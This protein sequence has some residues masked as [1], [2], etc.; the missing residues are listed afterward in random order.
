VSH[1]KSADR[2]SRFYQSLGFRYT[3]VEEEGELVMERA[4]G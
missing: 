2:L 3:G 4:L 1:V